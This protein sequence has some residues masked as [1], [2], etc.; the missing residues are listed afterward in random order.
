GGDAPA[1]DRRRS[2]PARAPRPPSRESATRPGSRPSPPSLA[3]PLDAPPH[4]HG[5][6]SRPGNCA[7]DEQK[8]VLRSHRDHLEVACRDALGA[9]PAGHP[10]SLE[11][12]TRIGAVADRSTVT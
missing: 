8:V 1:P 5:A 11:V 12:A 10:L 7:A 9:V 6:V 3:P 4:E 2:S